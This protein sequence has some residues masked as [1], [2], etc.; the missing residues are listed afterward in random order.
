MKGYPALVKDGREGCSDRN[1]CIL[2]LK[3]K[4]FKRIDEFTA[5]RFAA[6]GAPRTAGRVRVLPMT[7]H[8]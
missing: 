8:A 5:L 3:Q 1:I 4:C 7:Q 2:S 6:T